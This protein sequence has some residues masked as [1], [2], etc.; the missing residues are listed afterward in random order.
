MDYVQLDESN[1]P[2]RS[3]RLLGHGAALHC[4]CHG[5]PDELRRRVLSDRP[6]LLRD[7]GLSVPAP[8]LPSDRCRL[9]RHSRDR[10]NFCFRAPLLRSGRP[11][12]RLLRCADL[13]SARSPAA[14]LRAHSASASVLVGGR[15]LQRNLNGEYQN[16]KIPLRNPGGPRP[17][18]HG[19]GER[20]L[21]V[22]RLRR[23]ML[24]LR[25]RCWL[26]LNGP[27]SQ[28][29]HAPRETGAR[30]FWSAAAGRRFS[31]HRIAVL[32]R[33]KPPIEEP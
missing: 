26:L 8:C 32:L 16:E 9:D 21:Q 7:R 4:R 20:S 28:K 27:P 1:R 33:S 10:S 17:V 3:A 24:P 19:H 14:S 25:L 2:P 12:E 31:M 15:K 22:H 13:T 5:Q 11:R 30:R 18:L 29:S 23:P 6:G